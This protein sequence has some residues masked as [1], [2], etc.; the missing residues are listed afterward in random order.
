[1]GRLFWKLF[2]ALFLALVSTDIIVGNIAQWELNRE[3]VA[4]HTSLHTAAE[5]LKTQPSEDVAKTLAHEHVPMVF[6]LPMPVFIMGILANL[7][8]ASLLAWAIAHPI[9]LLLIHLKSA[10]EG[11][12]LVR[13]S[14]KIT[15]THDEFSGLGEAFDLMAIRLNNMIKS[16]SKMMHHVSHELR[17]PLARIQMAVGLAMQNPQKIQSSLQRVELEAVRMERMI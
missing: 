8:F 9:K 10:A 15:A 14:P 5:Q 11:D 2:A 16:Q 6:N 13:V 3:L 17:S 12:L 7:F 4:Y 1:M